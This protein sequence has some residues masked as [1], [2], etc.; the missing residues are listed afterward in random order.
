MPS[1]TITMKKPVTEDRIE[2]Y[3]PMA[4]SLL[5]LATT[6]S[7]WGVIAAAALA[8]II[9]MVALD[10]KLDGAQMTYALTGSMEPTIQVGQWVINKPVIGG[11]LTEGAVITVEA[12][13]NYGGIPVSHRIVDIAPDGT[14]TT[15][16]DANNAPDEYHPQLADVKNIVSNVVS[17]ED[18][19]II[20][21]VAMTPP[22]RD[23]VT[24]VLRGDFSDLGGLKEGAP[25]AFFGAMA[26]LI[27]SEILDTLVKRFKKHAL[28]E[29]NS[30]FQ[31]R[32]TTPLGA[33]LRTA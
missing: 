21:L 26:L 32:I 2:S 30:K 5:K 19:N 29:A 11:E 18:S 7:R 6:V 22:Y 8:A 28:K 33:V 12:A 3:G 31:E 25:L 1:T 16:G 17:V 4:D 13:E 24:A 15:Q 9:G 14:I 20:S 10:L 27:L 23:K